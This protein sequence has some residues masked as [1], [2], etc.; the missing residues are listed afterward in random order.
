MTSDRKF[1]VIVVGGGPGGSVTGK[2]CVEAGFKTLLLEKRKLPRDKVCSGMIFGPWAKD[3]IE[4]KFGGIPESIL[5]S[6]KY[7]SGNMFHVPGLPPKSLEWHTPIA[8]R[9]DLDYWPVKGPK[10]QGSRYGIEQKPLGY[11]IIMVK[12]FESN[13]GIL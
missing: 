3:I 4:E 7:L 5:A 11:Q 13:S 2:Q 9:K 12:H 6:P 1:D 10:Q 8:W